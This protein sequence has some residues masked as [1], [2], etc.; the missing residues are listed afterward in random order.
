MGKQLEKPCALFNA[1]RITDVFSFA[2]KDSSSP[3]NGP[4][5]VKTRAGTPAGAGPLLPGAR[6][7]NIGFLP[8]GQKILRTGG[9]APE[10][11]NA[12]PGTIHHIR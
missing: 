12:A 11:G 6:S 9:I 3:L 4:G 2:A 10:P 5:Q 1:A 7:G 8:A